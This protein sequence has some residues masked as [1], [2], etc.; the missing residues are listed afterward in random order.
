[1]AIKLTQLVG[2]SIGSTMPVLAATGIINPEITIHVKT[3]YIIKV[4]SFLNLKNSNK[5][6]I[7]LNVVPNIIMYVKD[8]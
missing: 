4:I 7:K 6:P 5:T 1:M 3:K 2:F 8:V